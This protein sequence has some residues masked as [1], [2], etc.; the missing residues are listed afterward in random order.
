MSQGIGSVRSICARTLLPLATCGVM[1][2]GEAVTAAPATPHALPPALTRQLTPQQQQFLMRPVSAEAA[3][4]RPATWQDLQAV[5][6][7]FGPG[8]LE[9]LLAVAN[10]HAAARGGDTIPH[11]FPFCEH[12][13]ASAR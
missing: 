10:R 12:P 5:R 3:A 1:A 13:A 2:C 7:W 6:G 4:G 9:A 8:E 11:C